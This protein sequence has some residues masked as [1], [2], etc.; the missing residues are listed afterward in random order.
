MLMA[1]VAPLGC[2]GDDV[3][4]QVPGEPPSAV[5]LLGGD[6]DPMVPGHC[7]LPFPSNVY[8]AD[9]PDHGHNNDGKRVSFGATTFP[10]RSNGVR[11]P[12]D[13][14]FDHDGFSASQAPFTHLPLARCSRCATPYSI[15]KSLEPDHPT[16]LLE[17]PTG[18]RV[19]HWVDM[20]MS[21]PNDGQEGRPDQRVLMIRPAARL[22]D[23]TRYIVALRNVDD[24]DGKLIEPS[25]VFQA[26]RAGKLLA[27]GTASEKWTTYARQ[28]L[29]SEI[30][31]ELGKAGVAR[32][33]LQVAWDY[34]TASKSNVTRH[35]VDMRDKALAVVGEAGP[36]LTV[37][38]VEELPNH[39]DLL[40]RIHLVMTVPLYLTSAS[41]KYDK[42]QPMDRLNLGPSGE[43]EQNGTMDWDVLVLVP[44]SVG[45]GKKHGLL[46]NGHGLL[47]DRT[48]GQDGYLARAANGQAWIAFSVNLFGFDTDSKAVA[49]DLL[50]G[51]YE[52]IKGFPERQMQGMVNQLLAMRMMMGRVAKDGLKSAS[53]ALV[54]DPAWIDPAV[55][56]YRGDSQ[57]GI[58]GASYMALSTDVT[59]GLLGET[60]M[61]YN[62]MLNRSVDWPMYALLLNGSFDFDGVA[63]QLMLGLMQM[64]WD[65]VEPGGL[66]PYLSD[67][68]L[69]G[70]PPHHVLIHV[71]RG[72]HQVTPFGAHVMA[73]TIGAVQLASND[74][75]QPVFEQLFGIE[76]V[77]APLSGRSALVEYDFGLKPLPKENVP[78]RDGCD[79]HDRVRDLEPSFQQQDQFFR[80]GTIGWFCT[81]ACNCNDA[82]KDDPDEELGCEATECK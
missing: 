46:Q 16:V 34:T 58:M 68:L 26:L 4:T 41:V 76:Q 62:L 22:R 31:T 38:G 79:P 57:G 51:N 53:G 5:P 60:A 13:L 49:I 56:A 71:A 69:P 48:E 61:P 73:R 21:T 67:D 15:E 64:T 70:T 39:P 42:G 1:S 65:R 3:P 24:V 80:T 6:C 45:S 32:E 20:D 40:R 2:S 33:N 11:I 78:A 10:A 44:K 30:F 23:S 36:E 77:Q 50:L 25:P 14:M 52:G 54:L 35:L 43:L 82:V 66:A 74:P 55:R 63:I 37:K 18:W 27:E 72:D 75:T 9:E 81:G 7:G 17:V 8:L 12:V 29:Y 47:G 59:R 28:E 19:P